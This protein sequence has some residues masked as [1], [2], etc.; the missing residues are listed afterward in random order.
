M[1]ASVTNSGEANSDD[2][3]D[4]DDDDLEDE[5]DD[6][7]DDD[8]EPGP[9]GELGAKIT[10]QFYWLHCQTPLMRGFAY[11]MPTRPDK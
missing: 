9:A 11:S 3:E 5:G 7:D 8:D 1:R 6:D 2:E 4:L 10:D